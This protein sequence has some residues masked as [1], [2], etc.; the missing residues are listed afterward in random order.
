[1]I[2]TGTSPFSHALH[3]L[4]RSAARRGDDRIHALYG[5]RRW[6]GRING[7]PGRLAAGTASALTASARILCQARGIQNLCR[8][9]AELVKQA[10]WHKQR[11]RQIHVDRARR[12]KS[13]GQLRHAILQAVKRFFPRCLPPRNGP[14]SVCVTL[15]PSSQVMVR[16]SCSSQPPSSIST[17]RYDVRWRFS[18][19]PAASYDRGYG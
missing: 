19:A 16:N 15:M 10:V 5:C 17:A 14:S 13:S 4:R 1:M 18:A 6:R 8:F 9:T 7:Y 11:V 2:I 3:R 12:S